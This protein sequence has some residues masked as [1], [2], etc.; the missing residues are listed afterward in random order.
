MASP[1]EQPALYD[2]IFADQAAECAALCRQLLGER[3]G[4]FLSAGCGTALVER[5]LPDAVRVT[6]FDLSPAM[7]QAAARAMPNA[8]FVV[9]RMERPPLEC[10]GEAVAVFAG[11]LSMAYLIDDNAQHA[12]VRWA[13]RQLQPGGRF[14][15]E[16]PLAWQPSRV[17]G[18][19]ERSADG[20]FRFRWLDCAHEGRHATA[21]HSE[22]TLR[23]PAGVEH[24]RRAPLAVFT[25]G[26]MRALLQAAGLR[27]VR[28]VAPYDAGTETDAPPPDCLRAVVCARR[29]EKR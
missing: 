9:G 29:D 14:I 23:D 20:T 28:F 25:P 27:E 7:V 10:A 2:A 24:T 19:E 16:V 12:F 6:G 3:E 8:S 13:A 1:Y 11:L 17:Q 4:R 26:G 21:L 15:A 5:E 18:I 22:L